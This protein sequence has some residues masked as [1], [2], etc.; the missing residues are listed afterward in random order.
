VSSA[1]LAPEPGT[2][3]GTPLE[4]GRKAVQCALCGHRFVT[5]EEAVACGGCPLQRRCAVLCCPR[6]GYQFVTESML[7]RFVRRLLTR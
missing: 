6:C 4:S 3:V 7:V 1:R 5:G 2:R